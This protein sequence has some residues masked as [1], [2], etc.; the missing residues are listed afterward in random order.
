M[1][2]HLLGALPKLRSGHRLDL[3]ARPGFQLI[4]CMAVDNGVLVFLRDT[5]IK[6]SQ[7]MAHHP[8]EATHVYGFLTFSTCI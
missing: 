8:T 5:E 3:D 4:A 2:F 1:Y 7:G 6:W